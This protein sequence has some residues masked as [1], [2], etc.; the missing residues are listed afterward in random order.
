MVWLHTKNG[1]YSVRLGYHKARKEMIN[2]SWVESSSSA[3]G[4]QIWKVL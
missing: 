3:K 2:E 4:Q 1:V